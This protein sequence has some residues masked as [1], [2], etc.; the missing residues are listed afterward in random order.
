[1]PWSQD[2]HH[3]DPRINDAADDQTD[4]ERKEGVRQEEAE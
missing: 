3:G 2:C 4:G 1:M